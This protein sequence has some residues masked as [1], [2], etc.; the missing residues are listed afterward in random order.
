M[1]H[2]QTRALYYYWSGLKQ[3]RLVPGREDIH[4]QQIKRLLPNL[5]ILERFDSNHFVFRL[6]GTAICERFGREF[7]AHNFLTLWRGEDRLQ[8]RGHLN[9]VIGSQSPGFITCRAET[10]DR[11]SID[12]EILMLPLMDKL[13]GITKIL[14]SAFATSSTDELGHRKLV[15][16]QIVHARVLINPSSDLTTPTAP[17][18]P[19]YLGRPHLRLVVSQSQT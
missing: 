15:N 10:I 3:G 6:A 11:V 7:R 4:P 2:P 14:G 16:Q 9:D 1:N 5:F 12:A 19:K 8:M 18:R 17:P 13:G